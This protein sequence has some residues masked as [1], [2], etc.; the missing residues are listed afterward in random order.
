MKLMN[1]MLHPVPVPDLAA[2]FIARPLQLLIGDAWVNA[3]SGKTF[4]VFD[5]A[6]GQPIAKAAEGDAADIVAAVAGAL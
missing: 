4:D 6:T 3:K 5:P 2:Q 1:V